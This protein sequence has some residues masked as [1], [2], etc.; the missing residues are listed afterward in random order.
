[1]LIRAILWIISDLT[2]SWAGS[3]IVG[4]ETA[5]KKRCASKYIVFLG[6]RLDK[7]EVTCDSKLPSTRKFRMTIREVRSMDIETLVFNRRMKRIFHLRNDIIQP[8]RISFSQL[9]CRKAI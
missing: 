2:I 3:R 9:I 6:N 1:M 7:H 8:T 4:L 5:L